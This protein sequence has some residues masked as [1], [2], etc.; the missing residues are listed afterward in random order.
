[1]NL[2]H[3]V[4][5]NLINQN[6]SN[7]P[8]VDLLRWCFHNY[9]VRCLRSVKP[10]GILKVR[11]GSGALGHTDDDCATKSMYRN[12]KSTFVR[13]TE[14]PNLAKEP[15]PHHCKKRNKFGFL[16]WFLNL[17]SSSHSSCFF[18]RC[19]SSRSN[20][21]LN[22]RSNRDLNNRSNRDLNNRSNRDLS[23]AIGRIEI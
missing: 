14:A 17:C 16:N 20:R 19:S 11:I 21:D 23:N 4:E 1:M 13:C 7:H 12:L 8:N 9:G 18:C 2:Q 6:F 10:A 15:D 22:N 5:R 3:C